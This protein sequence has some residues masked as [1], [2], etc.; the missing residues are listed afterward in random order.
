LTATILGVTGY[1]GSLLLRMLLQHSGVDTIVPVSRS[2]GGEAL[3]EA[4]SGFPATAS[5]KL[6]SQ[7]MVSSQDAE[8]MPTNV[9][10]SAL[11]HL[12]SARAAVPYH[13]RR[14]ADGSLVFI[15][16]AADFRFRDADVFSAAYGQA[17]PSVPADTKV[18]YGL[19]ELHRDEVRNADIIANPGCYPTATLLALLP[20][21]R[22]GALSGP[23]VVNAMSGITGAGGKLAADYLFNNRSENAKAYAPGSAH[24]H[25]PEIVEQ[26][27]AGWPGADVEVDLIFVPHLV[28]MRRGLA[29]SIVAPLGRGW[30]DAAIAQLFADTYRDAPFIKLVADRVPATAD[31]WGSNRCDI[32]WR[33]ERGRVLLFSVID[34]L[35]KG[36]AGQA[37]QNFNL[38]FGFDETSGLPLQ[39]EA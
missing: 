33:V 5:L 37:V 10:F 24:R 14:L 12:E 27:R 22:A 29:A 28:P 35:I 9:V 19:S 4:L 32:G 15:D 23:I 3:A 17:P 1:T 6:A 26:L 36:A 18:A 11:P 25:H 8:G 7:S 13:K 39:A 2:R 20:L 30:S 38:R 34:N 31:V 16:L 21:A